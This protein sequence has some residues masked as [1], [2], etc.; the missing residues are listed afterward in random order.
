M[1]P[2]RL[3]P[4]CSMQLVTDSAVALNDAREIVAKEIAHALGVSARG[5]EEAHPARV[6]P[7]PDGAGADA[8]DAGRIQH[9]D[10]GG[11]GA[12]VARA[13]ACGSAMSSAM[14]MSRSMC[15]P[16]LRPSVCGAM[17]TPARAQRRHWRSI[18]LMLDELVAGGFDDQRIAELSALDDGRWRG[19][20]DDGVVVGASDSLVDAALDEEARRDDVDGFADRVCDGLHL[21]AA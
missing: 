1:Q 20:G 8:F 18:G 2:G 17:S 9:G 14:G 16:M 12:E 13:R 21:L 15:A 10:T 11:V 7:A 4:A 6:G 5:V 3:P 19:S